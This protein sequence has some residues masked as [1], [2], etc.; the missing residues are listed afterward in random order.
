MSSKVTVIKVVRTVTGLGLKDAKDLVEAAPKAVKEGYSEKRKQKKSRKTLKKLA[1]LLSLNS[2]EETNRNFNHGK[3]VHTCF[4]LLPFTH[5][6]I[7][8]C[9]LII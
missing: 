9:D 5:E 1:P 7:Y 4:P 8:S 6:N 3:H 2:L